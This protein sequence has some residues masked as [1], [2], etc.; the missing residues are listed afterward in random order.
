M[1]RTGS[2]KQIKNLVFAPIDFSIPESDE[3]LLKAS[4]EILELEKFAKTWEECLEG[5]VDILKK[6]I[7]S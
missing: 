4:N 1:G 3:R 2:T 6:W 7:K 5:A